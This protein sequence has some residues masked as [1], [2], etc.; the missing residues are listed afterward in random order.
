MFSIFLNHFSICFFVFIRQIARYLMSENG[1]TD[2]KKRKDDL[3][4]FFIGKFK[5]VLSKQI[6]YSI[7]L[8]SFEQYHPDNLE[9]LV[10]DL[11]LPLR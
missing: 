7:Y 4:V 6:I 5:Q 3:M 9:D 10:H 8:F 1:E 2:R 11:L